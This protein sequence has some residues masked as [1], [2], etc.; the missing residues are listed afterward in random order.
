M[1][2]N[3]NTFEIKLSDIEFIKEDVII[4][5]D[6]GPTQWTPEKFKVINK[7]QFKNF[8]NNLRGW[9]RTILNKKVKV[10]VV[11]KEEYPEYYI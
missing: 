6:L 2:E 1:N 4:I 5:A 7:E 11:T 8:K 9:S 10:Q 3:K